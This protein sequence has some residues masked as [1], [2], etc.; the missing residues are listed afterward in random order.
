[1]SREEP[2]S[3][4]KT[5]PMHGLGTARVTNITCLVIDEHPVWVDRL[6]VDTKWT[7]CSE[8]S[9]KWW[10]LKPF[11]VLQSMF[12]KIWAERLNWMTVT[13]EFLLLY[14]NKISH[15]L[16]LGK[17]ETW[18][19]KSSYGT[20]GVLSWSTS[21]N[22]TEW[23]VTV[24]ATQPRDFVPV[25]CRNSIFSMVQIIWHVGLK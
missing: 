1:M 2:V 15:S 18:S 5:W 25:F 8:F 3:G 24:L 13:L 7:L 20:R 11:K 19:P 14:T 12:Q 10:K 4:P 21:S 17:I 6:T 16:Q 22:A 23:I 9:W